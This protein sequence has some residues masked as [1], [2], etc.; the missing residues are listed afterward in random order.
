MD[1]RNAFFSFFLFFCCQKIFGSTAPDQCIYCLVMHDS[2]LFFHYAQTQILLASSMNLFLMLILVPCYAQSGSWGHLP[3]FY[4][5]IVSNLKISSSQLWFNWK[6]TQTKHNTNE[7]KNVICT[8]AYVKKSLFLV[9]LT[10][11]F[12]PGIKFLLAF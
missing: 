5:L 2:I 4:R 3:T 11:F 12:L 10:T 9:I 1:V 8:Q 6:R 7:K